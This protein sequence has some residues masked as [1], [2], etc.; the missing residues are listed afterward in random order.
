MA[1]VV[2]VESP[3]GGGKG[4]FLKYL[5]QHTLLQGQDVAVCLQD[6]SISNVMDMNNDSRRWGLFTEMDFLVRHII[7][8]HQAHKVAKVVI[9]EGSPISDRMCYFAD[10]MCEALEKRLYEE[11]YNILEHYWHVD[12]CFYLRSSI[13]SHFDRV[14]GNSKK[15]QSFVTLQ[16]LSRKIAMYDNLLSESPMVTCENNFEDNEPVMHVMR[17]KLEYA[18]KYYQLKRRAR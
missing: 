9:V 7:S 4:F 2:S 13:H 3:L 15:E 10:T 1:L 5:R 11:W 14:M 12:I 8:I 16:Y 6:D 18:L 17:D